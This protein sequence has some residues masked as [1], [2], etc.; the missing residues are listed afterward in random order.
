MIRILAIETSCDETAFALAEASGPLA[1]P[2]FKIKKTVIASQIAIHAEWGGVVPNIAKREH[3]KNLPLI[4]EKSFLPLIRKGPPI[5][6]LALTIG[7]GLAPCLWAGA[8]F[9]QKIHREYM[10]KAKIVGVN[11]LEGHLFSFLAGKKNDFSNNFPAIGLIV[12]GG[13]TILLLMKS[14]TQWQKIGETRDDAVGET[15]DKVA[16]MLKLPYPGGPLIEKMARKKSPTI[17]FPRPMLNQ[18]NYDFSFAG[19]KTAVLYFLKDHSEAD[20]DDVASSFQEAALE[21]L[22][23]K[24]MRAAQEFKARAVI[25]AG[26]VAANK[27]LRKKLLK[28]TKKMKIGFF[29]PANNLNTDNAAMIAVAAYINFLQKRRRPI[30]P[31]PNLTV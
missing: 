21:T 20:P 27:Q 30:K 8:N 29:A 9:A 26:G 4:F 19:L 25:L 7:P 12:S 15:F 31:Q 24:T 2:I 23:E 6:L 28:A 22:T 17:A 10:P 3:E 14:L 18:K 1:K 13:H 11:H 16:R 5:D